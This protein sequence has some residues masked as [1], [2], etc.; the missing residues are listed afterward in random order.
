MP[1]IQL[2]ITIKRE[3]EERRF[4]YPLISLHVSSHLPLP[5]IVS[6]HIRCIFNEFPGCFACETDKDGYQF[7]LHFHYLC[8]TIAFILS[9][10]LVGKILIAFP[11]VRDELANPTTAAPLGLL[12][13]AFEKVFAGNFG[14]VGEG[15][16]FVAVGLHTTV[17]VW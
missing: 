8:S 12:C 7:F 13:M 5:V 4:F 15:I 3:C 2:I 6:H 9:S 14:H 16:T 17:A 11:V 10:F 1:V